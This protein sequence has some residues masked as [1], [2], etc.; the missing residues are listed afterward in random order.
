MALFTAKRFEGTYN[1]VA[2][3]E[4]HNLIAHDFK[5]P[6]W[7]EL[8]PINNKGLPTGLLPPRLACKMFHD[9]ILMV[10]KTE[11]NGK[12]LQD[13][14]PE[15]VHKFY[16]KKQFRK[17][18]IEAGK[19]V[20]CRLA[21]GLGFAPN[22]VAEEVFVYCLL[23]DAFDLGWR[24]INQYIEDL[25]ET[26]K[27]KDYARVQRLMGGEDIAV[28]YRS[29]PDAKVAVPVKPSKEAK[30]AAKARESKTAFSD[31][32]NWFHAYGTDKMHDHEI[33]ISDDDEPEPVGKMETETAPA[34]VEAR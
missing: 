4:W 34:A 28:L 16:K 22:C 29:D 33:A 10:N 3:I 30:E 17:Q 5:Q 31:F 19:R 20:V 26:E 25:P 9:G 1:Q 23:K 21:V 15:C 24:R 13:R 12:Y 7:A 2:R 14:L 8:Y 32:R 6:H 27:D 11:E 18:C